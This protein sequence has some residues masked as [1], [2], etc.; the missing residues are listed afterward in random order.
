VVAPERELPRWFSWKR[1]FDARL[2]DRLV[3]EGRLERPEPGW[4]SLAQGE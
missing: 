4:I 1:L 2:V 3:D